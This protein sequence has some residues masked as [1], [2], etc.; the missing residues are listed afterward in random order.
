MVAISLLGKETGV[1]VG[2]GDHGWYVFPPASYCTETSS[3]DGPWRR[4]WVTPPTDFASAWTLVL[5]EILRTLLQ[6]SSGLRRK[7]HVPAGDTAVVGSTAHQVPACCHS[8][9]CGFS[10][11]ESV[12]GIVVNVPGVTDRGAVD[13]CGSRV[14]ERLAGDRDELP[15]VARGVQGELHHAVGA[16]VAH[17]AR[18]QDRA[19]ARK[20]GAAGAD[21]ELADP[22]SRIGVPLASTGAKRS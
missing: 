7:I 8:F 5:S 6:V 16:R 2:L 20:R 17:L 1:A 11:V 15:V 21:H 22:E 3:G 9:D 12:T 4:M 19:E 10:P 18:R 13:G 14:G